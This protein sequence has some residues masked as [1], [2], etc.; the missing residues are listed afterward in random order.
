[1]KRLPLI[2]TG[3]IALLAAACSGIGSRLDDLAGSI[4][5]ISSTGDFNTALAIADSLTADTASLD[6][7]QSV[8]LMAAW[9]AITN[10][11]TRLDSADVAIHAMTGFTAV[12]SSAYAKD[13]SATESQ[14]RKLHD[15]NPALD[16]NRVDTLYTAALSQLDALR[17]V[18][19]RL[20]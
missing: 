13:S 11:A 16:L 12:Y 17:A 9:V 4:D 5:S 1:M 2:A 3:A 20:R 19:S 15:K 18:A 10:E 7:S 8:R 6:P 14:I